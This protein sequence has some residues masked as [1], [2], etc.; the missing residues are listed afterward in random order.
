MSGT[1]HTSMVIAAARALSRRNAEVCGVDPD[2]TWKLYGEDFKQDAEE[3]LRAA[4]V[5]ELL[6][7]LKK[8]AAV[9]AGETMNKNGLIDALESARTAIAKAQP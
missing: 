6:D 4:G 7:A 5:P 8:C 2:D 3:A 1:K 9:C